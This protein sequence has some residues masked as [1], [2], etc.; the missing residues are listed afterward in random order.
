MEK[1]VQTKRRSNNGLNKKIPFVKFTKGIF[2]A[3]R[4]SF[5]KPA[6][7]TTSGVLKINDWDIR[8]QVPLNVKAI[9]QSPNFY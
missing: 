7:E 3:D 5:L 2:N 6:Q 9:E 8:S 1:L 4:A